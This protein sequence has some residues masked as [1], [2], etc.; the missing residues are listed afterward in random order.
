MNLFKYIKYEI[1]K[2]LNNSWVYIG[3]AIMIAMQIVSN[4]TIRYAAAHPEVVKENTTQKLIVTGFN[5]LQNALNLSG[6]SVVM[7]VV[8]SAYI[9]SDF[10]CGLLKS[11]LVSGVKRETIFVAK[12]IATII[13]SD[14]VAF[15]IM[16]GGFVIGSMFWGIGDANICHVITNAIT[17]ICIMNGYAS[18]FYSVAVVIKKTMP[19]VVINLFFP[20]IVGMLLS[21]LENF[22]HIHLYR[23]WLDILFSDLVN[24][25]TESIS[26][27]WY[28][29]VAFTYCFV[30]VTISLISVKSVEV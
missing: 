11:E 19:T 1:R 24:V 16:L 23:I 7:A 12:Y 25:T 17:Q 18:I 27:G 9:C 26:Y 20:S 14:I 3:M 13:I 30:L 22:F 6:F 4:I 15:L 8:I 29:A 28:I 21:F 5:G 2:I 10:R